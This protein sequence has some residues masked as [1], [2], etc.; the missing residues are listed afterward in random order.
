MTAEFVRRE[1]AVRSARHT[2]K[3]S[4]VGGAFDS[5]NEVIL[6]PAG[7]VLRWVTAGGQVNHLGM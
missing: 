1:D 6:R 3:T 4:T 2:Y 7:L 5:I